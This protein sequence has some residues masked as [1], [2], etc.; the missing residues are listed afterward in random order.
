MNAGPLQAFTGFGIELEYMLVDKLTLDVRPIADR[1]LE[2]AV[3]PKGQALIGCSNELVLH[4][5]EIKNPAPGPLAALTA[6]FQDRVVELNAQLDALNA[7]LMPTGMHP[8]MDPRHETV[9]WPHDDQAIYATY[10]RLFDCHRH[11][12]ANVQSMHIN[13]PFADDAEFERLLAAVRMLLPIL[14]AIAASSPLA[15]GRLTGFM[16][17]RMQVYPEQ[18]PTQPTIVGSLIPEMVRSRAEHETCVLAPMYRAIEAHD[19]GHHLRCEWLNA[20]AAIPRFDRHAIEIRVMDTQEC[21]QADVAL[22]A[23]VIDL[24]HLLYHNAFA[25]LQTQR[26]FSTGALSR[27][28]TAC[29]RDAEQAWIDD[30]QYLSILGYPQKSCTARALWQHLG[31]VLKS[32]HAP[33]LELWHTQLQLILDYGPLARR[34]VRALG[35]DCSR[36]ALHRVYARLAQTLA[37]GKAFIPEDERFAAAIYADAGPSVAESAQDRRCR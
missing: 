13:L 2:Q 37:D 36:A 14:P 6:G 12:W 1:L 7:R 18:S 30:A 35:G 24:A 28:L 17:Y 32:H 16:D 10:H 23:L 8:W 19:P 20:R 26:N 9:L 33:H 3:K 34:I 29:V 21:P 4:V 22:A 27:I 15:E 5:V 31:E 25:G 11:P